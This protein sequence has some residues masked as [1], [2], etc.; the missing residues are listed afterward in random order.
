[1][2]R[3]FLLAVV[4]VAFAGAPAAAQLTEETTPGLRLVYADGGESFLVP[5]ATR[6]TLNALAFQ[7]KLFGYE[8]PRELT[9]LL[10]DLADAGNGGASSVPHDLVRVQIAPLD[11]SFETIPANERMNTIM[12]HELVHV[13]TMDQAARRERA[14]RRLFGG[15]VVPLAEH[16]ESILYFY[17]TAPRVA[18]PR[19]YLE[20]IAV[21]VDTWMAGGLGRAQGGYDE[22]VFRTMVRD[23]VPFRDPLG[24]VSEGTKVDFQLEMNSYLYGTRF[25]TWLAHRYSPERVIAWTSRRDG[26]RA[27]YSAQFR[28]VFGVALENAWKSWVN[29][30]RAFQQTNLSAIQ[31]H[32]VTPFK[33]VTSH[34][35][36]SVSRAYFDRAAN[37]IYAAFNYPGVAAHIGAIDARDG[38]I[39]RMAS[40]KGPVIYTVASLA[41][42]PEERVLYYTTDNGAWRDLVRLEV[43]TGKT[44]LLLKDARVGDLAFN[45]SDGSL[46]GIRRSNGI[47]TVVRMPR[48]HTTWEEIA[49][50]PYGTVVYDLDVSPDGTT[51]A[52]SFGEIS[53]DQE[54]RILNVDALEKGDLTPIGRF[55]FEGSVPNGFTFSPDGRYLY[56]TSYL[57][58]VSNVFRH[59]LAARTLESVSNTETGFFRPVP[60]ENDRLLVFRYTGQGFVPSWIDARPVAGVG[61]ITLLGE[62]LASRHPQLDEWNVGSPLAINYESL[63]RD[64]RRYRVAGS[65]KPESFYP[66]VQGYKS[67][68]ALGV[69]LNFSD[70]VQLNRASVTASFTP[71]TNLPSNERLHASAEYQRYDWRAR[72]SFN[73]ADFYD[74]FGPTKTGRKGYG[75]GIGHTH[76]IIFDEPRH[77]TLDI[78]GDLS[79]GLDRVPEYQNVAVDV[80]RLAGLQARLSFSDVRSSLGGVD[81]ESGTKWA[82]RGDLRYVNGA[83]I[84]RVRVDLARGVPLPAGHSSI[85]FRQWA[86]FSPSRRTLAFANFYF[87]GFGNN[88]VDTGNEKRYRESYAFPGVDLNGI[89]GRNFV[90]SMVEVNLPPVRFAHVGTPGFHAT[91]MRPALFATALLTNLDAASA[92]R[93]LVN[94]GAQ[95]DFR[96]SFLSVLDLTASVGG[97]MAFEPGH[98]P[99][100]ELMVSLKVLR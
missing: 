4:F 7:R 44:R 23:D 65:L 30:E 78:D 81:E 74:L 47:C 80:R 97:G 45:N 75:F 31:E 20:G 87:G 16:P 93:A 6:T 56:G 43:E 59:D 32:P 51:L 13:A 68:T 84:P 36:G 79:G 96:F 33:D 98:A 9:V 85:W 35:L 19:W 38:S 18:A 91:W 86:G 60:L 22:M 49:S 48:P 70:P 25:I 34:A 64:R 1:M 46:W 71:G 26:S 15:K 89:G 88:Y 5:H 77:L 50:W 63:T 8:P 66:I 54:V 55:G 67:T 29:E 3:R 62:R 41:W 53:G 21:F 52:A 90:K 76:T 73:A 14:F 82:L 69:R 92:R 94:A 42:N 37:R 11:L 12:N 58:G 39:E 99:R 2:S 72:A 57:T 17:L 83:L 95:L 40:I 27:Y 61:T 10:M 24:L 100:R 28:T